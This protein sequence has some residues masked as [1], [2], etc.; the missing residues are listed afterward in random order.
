[1]EIIHTTD[2]AAFELYAEDCIRNGH[3]GAV[4]HIC[5][6]PCVWT[7]QLA[8]L[9]RAECARRGLPVATGRYLA[10]SI[11]NMPGDLSICAATWGH[12]DLAP[13][14]VERIAD[15]LAARWIFVTRDGNDV[16]ADGEK[17]VSWAR[18]MTREGWEQSV[19][20]C[21]VGP[22]D[23]DLVRAVCTK[24]MAKEPGALSDY[25]IDA[26]QIWEQVRYLFETYNKE[27]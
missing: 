8:T 6:E 23:I 27:E 7:G 17:V 20:H 4:V 5:A 3:E 16:L 10:G 18:A 14:S 13:R 12:S 22:M 19:V 26:A 15:Y 9:D 11:V 1:M 2:P 25:G 24:E 21:S